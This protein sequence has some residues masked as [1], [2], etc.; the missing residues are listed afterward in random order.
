MKLRHSPTSFSIT[1]LG[2]KPHHRAGAGIVRELYLRLAD[3]SIQ[4]GKKIPIRWHRTKSW[5]VPIR[6]AHELNTAGI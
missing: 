6:T 5:R 3:K 2:R 1:S 4:G